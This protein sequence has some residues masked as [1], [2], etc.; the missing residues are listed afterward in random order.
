MWSDLEG[1]TLWNIV[2]GVVLLYC[3]INIKKKKKKTKFTT[4]GVYNFSSHIVST[5]G[6]LRL[7]F[8]VQ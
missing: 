2:F 6:V 4:E 3:D 8:A 5:D 1:K 7:L